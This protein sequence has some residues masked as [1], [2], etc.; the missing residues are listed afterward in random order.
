MLGGG[1]AA[2]STPGESTA[3]ATPVVAPMVVAATN[4]TIV[5]STAVA[6]RTLLFLL[7]AFTSAAPESA[8]T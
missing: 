2:G 8:E 6:E 5:A 7:C 3:P 1:S 4:V